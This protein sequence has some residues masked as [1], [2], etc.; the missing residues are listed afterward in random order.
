MTEAP[1]TAS[2]PDESADAPQPT[3]NAPGNHL[4]PTQEDPSSGPAPRQH[5]WGDA[6]SRPKHSH[7]AVPQELEKE[8]PGT[9]P[10][11]EA[12]L[13]SA[14]SSHE[15]HSLSVDSEG[16]SQSEGINAAG[17]PA[18][19]LA[20]SSSESSVAH[21]GEESR[22]EDDSRTLAAL[23]GRSRGQDSPP[24][25]GLLPNQVPSTT[26]SHVQ[27][28]GPNSTGFQAEVQN[29]YSGEF[30][31]QQPVP[32]ADLSASSNGRFVP[33]RD[34]EIW[35]RTKSLLKSSGVVTLC[36]SPGTGRRTAALHLLTT[37]ISDSLK[38]IDLEPEWSKPD[39]KR[40]PKE[41]SHGYILDL[42]DMPQ[43]PGPRFGQELLNYGNEGIKNS[44]YLVIL[45]TPEEWRGSWKEET[46]HITVEHSSPDA[47]SLARQ[48]LR[49]LKSEHRIPWLDDDSYKK[50]WQSNPPAQETRRLARIIHEAKENDKSIIDEF[51]GWS[52]HI[53]SLLTPTKR[54]P[55]VPELIST[56]ATVWAGALVNGGR[57]QSILHA[58]DLLL[59]KLDFPREPL[60]ILADA[61]SSNRMTAASLVPLGDRVFHKP[62]KHD[63][64]PA[65]LKHL[66][67]EFPTQ[68][69][70][71]R[72]WV[73]SVAAD[74]KIPEDDARIAV[75][76]L[77]NLS[78]EKRDNILIEDIA[79][80]ISEYRMPLAVEALTEAALDP[81][82]GKYVRERLYRWVLHKPLPTVVDLVT[83]ICGGKL[84][85][86]QPS[87]AITR[88]ARAA[89]H[90]Q[91]SSPS[92][93]DAFRQ[94]AET[95]PTEVTNALEAWLAEEP[96]KK[97]GLVAFLSLAGSTEGTSLLLGMAGNLGGRQRFVRAW[98]QLIQNGESQNAANGQLDKWGTKAENGDLPSKKLM[99]LMAEVYEIEIFQSRLKRFFGQSLGSETSFWNEVLV[100]ARVRNKRRN[101]N[102][103]N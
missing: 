42:S 60:N 23:A 75:A 70:T 77:L 37:V 22:R 78:K 39:A 12:A 36:A 54:G 4:T 30:V 53:D 26:A 65:I 72:S 95:A 55:G 86:Q 58:A 91:Y 82:L 3:S 84:A 64:A 80:K 11:Q 93:V 90:A 16:Q 7:S 5:A 50:I 76:A 10:S 25:Y 21:E 2:K 13:A 59:N 20:H 74:Q 89:V 38:I 9:V 57:K 32:L 56:R 44:Y 52:A 62:D 29:F 63:L 71:L 81:T 18:A 17:D 34:I 46:R 98:Q 43:Q 66:W 79:K 67:E 73:I 41:G 35:E 87:I 1:F 102:Q 6:W 24:P 19:V 101:D 97:H 88:L 31:R 40:L 100:E 27:N 51:Q 68:L 47:K 14:D 92:M 28:V 61:T 8:S 33:P 15:S 99:D 45:T 48:E 83:Q 69:S 49:Q 96:A 85:K 94:L 103:G